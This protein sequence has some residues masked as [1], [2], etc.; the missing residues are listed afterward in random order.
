FLKVFGD[1]TAIDPAS[2]A[3]EDASGLHPLAPVTNTEYRPPAAGDLD[4]GLT[5]FTLS[6]ARFSSPKAVYLPAPREWD[7]D[8]FL[9]DADIPAGLPLELET[10]LPKGA[11]PGDFVV[12]AS[13]EQ[14]AWARIATL[15]PFSETG[16]AKLTVAQW[17]GFAAGGGFYLSQTRVRTR[18]SDRRRVDGWDYNGT[19]LSG[20]MLPIV[21]AERPELLVI[22]RRL[23]IEQEH[24]GPP[25]SGR[26]ATVVDVD[27]SRGLVMVDPGLGEGERFTLGNTVIRGN[28]VA[29]G[30]GEAQ[31]ER[32]LGSGDAATLNQSFLLAAA[33]VSFVADATMPAGVRADIDVVVDG[34]IWQAAA[35]LKDS[36]PGDPHYAV[37][38]TEQG[39]LDIEFG[40]GE[41]GRRLPT[42]TNNVR[43]RFR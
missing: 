29:A 36:A 30:H 24:G 10:T 26:E 20:P 5:R 9:F 21:D 18:F 1:L 41:R 35:S 39:F 12:L 16:R 6:T 11:A 34:Q 23:W 2:I 7:A 22:G 42:G 19:A 15:V 27:A 40:D 13:G 25:E 32:I 14:L 31:S 43:V 17:N 3:V 38:M 8:S 33:G 28:V 37:R 4:S